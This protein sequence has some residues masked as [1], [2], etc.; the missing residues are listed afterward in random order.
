MPEVTLPA[1]MRRAALEAL[2]R[3]RL[4]EITTRFDLA[5]QDRRAVAAHI[6]A[7]VRARSLDFGEVLR[8]LQRDELKAVCEALGLDTSGKEKEPIVQR[9]LG[10]DDQK[11]LPLPVPVSADSEGRYAATKPVKKNGGKR[12]R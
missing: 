4:G 5:V 2:S 3:D 8:L 12:K 11:E 1:K 10:A 6:E 9:I 7:I